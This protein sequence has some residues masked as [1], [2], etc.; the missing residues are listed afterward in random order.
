MLR[1]YLISESVFYRTTVRSEPIYEGEMKM[2][3]YE[4]PDVQIVAL[5]NE[6]VIATS[7]TIELP[8]LPLTDDEIM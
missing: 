3:Q 1:Y 4:T 8:W 7:V 2:K 5:S 6:D